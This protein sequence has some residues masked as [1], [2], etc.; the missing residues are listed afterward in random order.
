MKFINL[1]SQ[2]FSSVGKRSRGIHFLTENSYFLS[3]RFLRLSILAK[4]CYTI[5]TMKPL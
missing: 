2:P 3:I 4:L 1:I 5:N